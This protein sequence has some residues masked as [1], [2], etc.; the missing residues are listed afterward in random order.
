MRTASPILAA[1]LLIGPLPGCISLYEP[2]PQEEIERVRDLH[3]QRLQLETVVDVAVRRIRRGES[4]E[5][6]CLKKLTEL[7]GERMKNDPATM[8]LI[9]RLTRQSFQ[10]W[11]YRIQQQEDGSQVFVGRTLA[12][13]MLLGPMQPNAYGLGVHSD[14]TGRPFQWVPQAAGPTFHDPFLNVQ[15]NA[16]GLGTGMDQYGRPVRPGCA[17]GWAGPC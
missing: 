9:Q 6:A 3:F 11:G 10:Q 17:P 12:G 2:I 8:E 13:Q 16:Y 4:C 14:A 7:V 5:E 1:I 15:P